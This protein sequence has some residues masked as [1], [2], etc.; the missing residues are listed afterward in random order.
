MGIP[1]DDVLGLA[2]TGLRGDPEMKGPHAPVVL[3]PLQVVVVDGRLD[4]ALRKLK[5]KMASEGVLKELKR[6][7][8]TLKP[9]DVKRRKRMEAARRRR[10]RLRAA[11]KRGQ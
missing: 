1:I 3:A 9:S 2:G 10:K 7:R 11:E 6:R 5:R 4:K 8:R